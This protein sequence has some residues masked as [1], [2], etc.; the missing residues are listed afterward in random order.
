MYFFASEAYIWDCIITRN[1]A[2]TSGGG[3]YISGDSN[4]PQI[5]NCLITENIAGR[6]GGGM[7][8][9]WYAQPVIGNCTFSGN[10]APG[11]WGQGGYTGFGGALYC[12]YHS[13]TEVTDCILWNNFGQEGYEITVATGFEFDP[14]P[15]KLRVYYSNVKGERGS[16]REEAGCELNWGPGNISVDPL[17]VTGPLGDYYLSQIEAGQV[18]QSPC[19]DAGSDFASNLKL[20]ATNL[21][22]TRYTTRTDERL[23]RGI[24]DMGFHY[25]TLSEACRFCDLL[26]VDIAGI[27]HTGPDG[28]VNFRDFAL[29]G[30][31]W[32]SEGCS[33]VDG[34]CQGADFTVDTFVEFQD[35]WFFAMCWLAEDTEPPIPNPSQWEVAPYSVS[36]T[37]PYAIDMTVVRSFDAWGW[38]VQYYLQRLDSNGI[39]DGVFQGWGPERTWTD[40]A[41]TYNTAYGYRAKVREVRPY[42]PES[43]WLQT[44]WSRTVY[45][46]AGIEIDETPPEPPP[47]WLEPNGWPMTTGPNSITM[48]ATISYDE[49]G[50][51]YYFQCTR[52]GGHHSGWLTFTPGV[53]PTYTDVNLVPSTE[54]CYQVMA[55]D[56]SPRRNATGWSVEGCATTQAPPD[57][58]APTPNPMDWEDPNSGPELFLMD[59]NLG[60]FGW[61]VR[62]TAATAVDDQFGV[63]YYFECTNYGQFSSQWQANPYYEVLIGSPY[64]VLC[65]RVKA[66]DTSPNHNETAWSEIRCNAPPF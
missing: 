59:P 41:V 16:V 19:V 48:T 51:E 52:G 64:T 55:R 44:D 29:V 53:Y 38:D 8:V 34:W 60:N 61:G 47:T 21:G 39:P 35:L 5:M 28:I 22:L 10:A 4:S 26:G 12:S 27:V 33:D 54:Y 42:R 65:F 56:M 7:S 31:Y 17:F 37:A 15:A 63:E 25:R 20:N 6:D 62:M 36:T 40:N 50:V 23:D 2:N 9:N 66:R 3:V 49:S 45:V 58:N 18:Q 30:L 32:L 24:V 43:E 14:R 11:L 13:V 57:V 46:T 1:V